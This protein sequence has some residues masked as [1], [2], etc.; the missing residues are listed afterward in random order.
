MQKLR[1]K[2]KQKQW[3]QNRLR[4]NRWYVSGLLLFAPF[5]LMQNSCVCVSRAMPKKEN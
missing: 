1:Q 4:K 2:Q 5:V 3:S